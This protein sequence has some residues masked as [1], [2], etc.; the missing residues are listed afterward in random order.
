MLNEIPFE[1]GLKELVCGLAVEGREENV[2]T[3]LLRSPGRK[4]SKEILF[5]ARAGP[6]NG[7]VEGFPFA[8]VYG[9]CSISEYFTSFPRCFV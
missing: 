5:P 3:R 8:A 6:V 4:Y 9:L 1:T 7:A 2:E